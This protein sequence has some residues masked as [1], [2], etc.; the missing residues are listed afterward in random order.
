MQKVSDAFGG[1]LKTAEDKDLKQITC[2]TS[3]LQKLKETQFNALV[4][5]PHS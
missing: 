2:Q 4:P 3:K 5:K 1:V